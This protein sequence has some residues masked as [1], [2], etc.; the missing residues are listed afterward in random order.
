MTVRTGG[1]RVLVVEN[2][3]LVRAH[4]ERFL[5]D[6]GHSIAGSARSAQRAIA[7][8]ERTRPDLVLMDIGLDGP[9]DGIYAARQIRD[10]FG[11]PSIFMSG[12]PDLDTC[13]RAALAEPLAHLAKPVSLEQLDEALRHVVQHP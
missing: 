3:A 12:L 1:L 10:R 13:D 8:A 6:L 2:E 7:E 9:E 5:L 4:V 11:I